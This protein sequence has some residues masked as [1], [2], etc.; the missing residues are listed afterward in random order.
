MDAVKLPNCS[1]FC[2]R[3]SLG[4]PIFLIGNEGKASYPKKNIR[5]GEIH[6]IACVNP[7]HRQRKIRSIA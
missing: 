6:H 4:T 5:R 3:V 7:P 1:T 2:N